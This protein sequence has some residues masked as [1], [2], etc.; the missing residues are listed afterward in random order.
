[1]KKLD[2]LF[3]NITLSVVSLLIFCLGLEGVTRIFWYP[4]IVGSGC[5]EA[6]LVFY[7][8][9]TPNCKFSARIAEGTE[10]I[11]YKMN[12]CGFRSE[13]KCS[14]DNEIGL[15]VLGMGDSFTFGAEVQREET[16]LHVFQKHLE[17]R[18]RNPIEVLNA[19]VGGWG[20]F[21]YYL[22]LEQAIKSSP[23][24]ITV[25]LL[26]NDFFGN[27]DGITLEDIRNKN[28][29]KGIEIS[30]EGGWYLKIKSFIKQSMF[31]NWLA[32]TFLSNGEVYATIY[33]TKTGEDSYLRKTYSKNWQGKMNLAKAVIS[34]MKA[35]TEK[36]NIKLVLVI[37]PQKAQAL[38]LEYPEKFKDFD[39]YH[40]SRHFHSIGN[41]LSVPVVD[42]IDFL[43]SHTN[44]LS[45]YFP[46]DGHLNPEGQKLLGEF[47]GN[48][49]IR[50]NIFSNLEE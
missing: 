29:S 32:H 30:V 44:P 27:F 36:N 41:E 50:Q 5:Y 23:D 8:H 46:L 10:L 13:S 34:K 6:D 38:L 15:Q 42:F 48:E 26:P 39:P 33:K 12:Q 2:S 25:G 40:F 31:L 17:N 7:R 9:N 49:F 20:I 21:Q 37:I 19:G 22:F 14:F 28:L 43:A 45:L 4:E 3:N 11:E 24:V 47:L 35:E 16:Y 18:L 1:M